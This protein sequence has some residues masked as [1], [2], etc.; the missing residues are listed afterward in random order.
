MGLL[1]IKEDAT[2]QFYTVIVSTLVVLLILLG[3]F[4]SKNAVLASAA[5]ALCSCFQIVVWSMLAYI[6]FQAQSGAIKP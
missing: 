4:S 3:A 2:S 5:I 1:F 6:A